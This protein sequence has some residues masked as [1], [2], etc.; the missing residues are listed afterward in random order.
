MSKIEG[1]KKW[2]LLILLQLV[3]MIY[4]LSGVAAKF[5]AGYEFLSMGFILCYGVEIC[6]LGLYAI[7][8]QQIIKRVD[9]S[10]AYANRSIAILWSMIWAALIFGEHIS[11]QNIIGV[12]LVIAG[13]VIV[14]K[15]E[16][17]KKSL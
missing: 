15:E 2:I 14:N 17:V 13:T 12:I 9:L 7:F 6:I 3:I 1:K 8:W 4:T 11:V 16:P 10:V 5:A